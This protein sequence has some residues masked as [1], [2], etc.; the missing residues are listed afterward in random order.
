[1]PIAEA[2]GMLQSQRGRHAPHFEQHHPAADRHA[3]QSLAQW[4]LKFSPLVGLD[5][6][7]S[8][9]GLLLD[10]SGCEHL[11]GGERGLALHM[12]GNLKHWGYSVRSAVADTIGTAWA[13]ARYAP[14]PLTIVPANRHAAT[15]GCHSE[16]SEESPST[17]KKILRSAQDDSLDAIYSLPV[18]ALRLSA[19]VVLQLRELDI[20]SIGQLHDLPRASLPSRFGPDVLLRLDQAL[21]L[22]P[23]QI[24]PIHVAE[25]PSA[26]WSNDETL[27]DQRGVSIILKRLLRRVLHQL[28]SRRHGIL[29]LECRLDCGSDLVRFSVRLA[30]ATATF[31]RLD[32]LVQL[33][34]ERVRISGPVSLIRIEATDTIPLGTQQPELFEAQQQHNQGELT[35]LIERLSSRLGAEA[36]CRPHLISDAQPE[37]AS[38]L[39]P[40]IDRGPSP[41]DD[42]STACVT[43]FRPLHLLEWPLA[44][45]VVSV[46]PAG[47]PIR[48]EWDRPYV[49]SRSWGPER[50]ATGWWRSPHV[51]RDYY[52]IEAEGGKRFWLFRDIK[53]GD[54]YLHGVFD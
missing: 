52:R 44:V 17:E 11:F 8:A 3:L 5:D 25:P 46:F 40:C 29:C 50:I 31:S 42:D 16:R 45:R 33:E 14:Q 39:L 12:Q 38:C 15:L 1:M 43:T 23:E 10:T 30:R 4:S 41:A 35:Q 34:L 26:T 21:G 20:R 51:E 7:N 6:E 19:S 49:V 27:D 37:H 28:A 32:E 9:E 13:L 18:E 48:F 36:V 47:P 53:D 2:K 54:W 22:I 24:E